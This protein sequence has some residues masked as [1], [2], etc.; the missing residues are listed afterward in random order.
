MSSPSSPIPRL[1][2]WHKT[3]R[4]LILCPVLVI[5][6]SCRPFPAAPAEPSVG[7]LEQLKFSGADAEI[8]LSACSVVTRLADRAPAFAA[9]RELRFGFGLV[10]DTA[11]HCPP[12]PLT[13]LLADSHTPGTMYSL[14]TW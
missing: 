8:S 11:D 4:M 13:R 6:N 14:T 7:P 12:C 9:L 5:E 1:Q 3:P 2:F 10:A